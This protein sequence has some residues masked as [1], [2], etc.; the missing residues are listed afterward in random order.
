MKKKSKR[1]KDLLKVAVKDKKLQL[2]E[3]SIDSSNLAVEF[4]ITKSKASLAV[5]FLSLITVFK[6]SLYLLDLFFIFTL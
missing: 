3:I 6:I 1:Y 2:K 5:N 4:F